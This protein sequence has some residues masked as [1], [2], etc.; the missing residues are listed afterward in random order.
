MTEIDEEDARD[1]DRDWCGLGEELHHRELRGAGEN[2]K[3]HTDDLYRLQSGLSRNNSEGRSDEEGGPEHRPPL[4]ERKA[5]RVAVLPPELVQTASASN[6][7]SRW[8]RS[9]C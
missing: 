1:D 6:S 3:T 2:Q 7:A 8:P 9:T 5:C 4:D